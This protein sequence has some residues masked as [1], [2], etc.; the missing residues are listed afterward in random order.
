MTIDC[1]LRRSFNMDSFKRASR[2]AIHSAITTRRERDALR[3]DGRRVR[4]ISEIAYHRILAAA[5]VTVTGQRSPPRLPLRL[6]AIEAPQSVGRRTTCVLSS[7]CRPVRD[8]SRTETA[9]RASTKLLRY[10]GARERTISACCP[11]SSQACTVSAVVVRNSS[12]SSDLLTHVGHG[13]LLIEAKEPQRSQRRR[14]P[15][16]I[17]FGATSGLPSSLPTE[18]V[19]DGDRGR[20]NG[21]SFRTST[22]SQHQMDLGFTQRGPPRVVIPSRWIPPRK[23]KRKRR[24]CRERGIGVH[25]KVAASDFRLQCPPGSCLTRSSAGLNA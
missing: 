9:R 16:A 22:G 20:L 8:M 17:W 7:M 10:K 3:R 24:A 18:F 5:N 12:S 2:F 4:S 6:R 1:D 14:P 15:N 25:E 21:A 23:G 13:R 19:T 11:K